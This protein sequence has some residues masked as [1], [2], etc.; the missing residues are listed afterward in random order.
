M[1]RGGAQL[2]RLRLLARLALGDAGPHVRR[3]LDVL[4]AGGA[5]VVLSPLLIT[6]AILVC[7]TS[8]GP[9]LF[10]QERIGKRGRRFLMI[11]LRTMRIGAD[12]EKAKLAATVGEASSGVRFKIKNDPRI[13]PVG[14]F[15]RKYSID[16]LPQLWNVVRGDLTLIGPRPAVW[17][18]VARYG[19]RAMRRLEVQQGLTC[20]WQVGGRSD[21]SFEQQVD[22]DIEY[23]DRA[24]PTD[25]FKIVAKTIPAVLSGRG[26]Y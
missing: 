7:A 11:K 23:V 15:L 6:A 17:I 21:L 12:A 5:L 3:I 22:L 8:P 9:A 14:R 16:E 4:V 10:F 1:A 13:T 25:E 18:E 20:L 26:A 19:A 24:T 2:R